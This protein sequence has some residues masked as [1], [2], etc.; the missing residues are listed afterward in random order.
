MCLNP[1][2]VKSVNP[3]SPELYFVPCGVCEECRRN[4][5]SG[6]SFRLGME[7]QKCLD[8]GWKIAFCT[9]TYNEEHLP[10]IP[11]ICFRNPADYTPIACFNAHQV[12]RFIRN[13]RSRL[14]KYYGVTGCKYLLSS[15]FG[16]KKGRP[17]YHFL[18]AFPYMVPNKDGSVT[19][20]VS[21]EDMHKEITELWTENGFV[22]PEKP[23]GGRVY[24][25]GEEKPFLL[26]TSKG[27]YLCAKYVT[28]YICKDLGFQKVLNTVDLVTRFEQGASIPKVNLFGKLVI[29]RETGEYETETAYS[30]L[31]RCKPLHI[32]SRSLGW[33]FFENLTDDEKL[34]CMREGVSFLGC[35]YFQHLPVYIKNKLVFDNRYIFDENGKR[36]VRRCANEF[37][38]D[39]A[40]EIFKM[41]VEGYEKLFNSICTINYWSARKVEE[42][43]GYS[44]IASLNYMCDTYKLTL[45]ELAECYLAYFAVPYNYCYDYELRSLVWLQRYAQ[46]PAY[47]N[48]T[49]FYLRFVD[50]PLISQQFKDDVDACF[51]NVF[52]CLH[53]CEV[54]ESE[55][56]K[57]VTELKKRI[58]NV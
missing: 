8:D 50:T 33:S 27:A 15:E 3:Q 37:F 52:S 14:E 1:I 13:L 12:R 40:D 16:E 24:E 32:Q 42:K 55:I 34:K 11:E 9:L 41:K 57:K 5:K 46:A 4:I 35:D 53:F 23:E 47:K 6:W 58:K 7:L 38:M 22:F 54:P 20:G 2:K 18:I 44:A 29:N 30:V 36:L 25:D 43:I 56:S 26:D 17:H 45:K 51:Y 10:H 28:K 19:I 39:H 48:K 21:P 49:A 31:K